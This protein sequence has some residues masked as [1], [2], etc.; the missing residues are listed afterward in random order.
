MCDFFRLRPRTAAA[1]G[2]CYCA[3]NR[4]RQH[5]SPVPQH[6]T[7]VNPRAIAWNGVELSACSKPPVAVK[8]WNP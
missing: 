4:W 7:K 3:V 1:G 5:L 8:H 2:T 6:S